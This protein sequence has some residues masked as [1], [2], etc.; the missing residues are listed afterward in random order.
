MRWRVEDIDFS[1]IDVQRATASEDLMLLL[2]AAS[3]V[4]SGSDL[5]SHTLVDFFDGDEELCAWLRNDWEAEELQHGRSLKAYVGVVWPDFDW[6]ASFDGFFHEYSKTCSRE[7]LEK[8]RARE[9]VA[10]CVIETGTSSLYSA[11]GQCSKE[12]VLVKLASCIHADEVHHYKVFYQYFKKYNQTERL[13]RYDVLRTLLR[14]SLEI[15]NEDE[16]I[17]MRHVMA[18]RYPERAGDSEISARQI[19]R[20]SEMVMRNLPVDMSVKMMIKP[21]GLPAGVQRGVL[22]AASWAARPLSR[23]LFS[24]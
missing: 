23:F 3:F 11:I 16:E 14:R 4:E 17:A 22:S 10:R 8:T 21:L 9:L 24:R 5:Y 1:G 19:G 15:R 7:Q 12:P 18:A 13:G 2:C 20:V 6:N